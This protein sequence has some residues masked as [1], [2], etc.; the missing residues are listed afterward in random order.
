MSYIALLIVPA[1]CIFY[2]NLA[3]SQEELSV[4]SNADDALEEELRYLE[5][6]T[7]VITASRIPEDIKKAASS[8]T[9]ITDRQIRQMGARHLGDVLQSVPG[10]SS[11]QHPDGTLDIAVRGVA[12]AASNIVLVMINGHPVNEN[13][14]GG[15]TYTHDT[16]ILDNVKRIEVIRGPGSALYGA[17]AFAGVINIIT[18]EA[19][20]IDGWELTARGGSYDTQQYNLLYG[21]TFNGLEVAFNYNYFNTHGFNGHLDRDALSVSPSILNRRAS[22]TPGR[23]QG[24]GEKD[25]FSLNL[26]YKG[27]TFDGKYVDRERDDTPSGEGVLRPKS[28]FSPRQYYLNLGYKRTFGEDIEFV[29]KVYRNHDRFRY[30]YQNPPGSTLLTPV[31]PVIMRDGE[32]ISD[33]LKNNRTGFEIQTT[34]KI[35]DTNTIVAGITYEEMK[36]YDVNTRR[37]FLELPFGFGIPLPSVR[38]LSNIQNWTKSVKRNFKAFFIE[39]IW[40]ITDDLRLTVGVRYD[41]YSDFG[42]EVSPRA[43]LVWEFKKGYDLKL[44]YGHAFRAPSFGELYYGWAGNPN[45]D[46]ETVDTYEVSLGAEFTPSLSSRVTFYHLEGE[47]NI[48]PLIFGFTNY[49]K[50]RLQGVELEAKYDVGRGTYLAM[51]YTYRRI[52]SPHTIRRIDWPTPRHLGNVMANIRLSKYLN[53]YASCHIE[54]GFRR[55]RGDPRDDMSGYAIVNTTLIA[56]KF[57]KGYEGLELRGSIYNLFDKDYTSPYYPTLLPGDLPRPGRNFLV[58]V[59]YKF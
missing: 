55:D 41:D 27:F 15:A 2:S 11:W 51:N 54:D 29:G 31:G 58:E 3:F 43:G 13:F 38:D 8:I 34:C 49:G 47:D 25:D 46:A 52:M 20:D 5:A 35:F 21:K 17:N 19:E 10:M 9:V 16:I 26:K 6:E 39:D 7:F 18:K 22:L 44:L 1:F 30:S 4:S 53:F 14:S 45:L 12:K 32:T 57:L 37:N 48:V 50:S 33:S 36:Q 28:S 42:N 59:K 23:L 56:K 24:D 40:D